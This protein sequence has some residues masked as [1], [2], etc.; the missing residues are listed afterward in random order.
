MP[1]GAQP[2][3]GGLKWSSDGPHM[4]LKRGSKGAECYET[5]SVSWRYPV[6]APGTKSWAASFSSQIRAFSLKTHGFQN[7]AFFVLSLI[8]RG[9]SYFS[10]L[11]LIFRIRLECMIVL[12]FW[13]GAFLGAFCFLANMNVFTKNAWFSENVRFSCFSCFFCWVRIVVILFHGCVLCLGSG[14]FFATFVFLAN[15]SIFD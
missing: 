2:E 11:F 8:D 12:V 4:E 7:V 1:S 9:C 10:F 15:M 6:A 13:G 3:P 5:P 14:A